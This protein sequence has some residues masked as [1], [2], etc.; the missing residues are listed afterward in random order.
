MPAD[1]AFDHAQEVLPGSGAS[2]PRSPSTF[3]LWNRMMG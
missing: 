1:F 2:A 3:L